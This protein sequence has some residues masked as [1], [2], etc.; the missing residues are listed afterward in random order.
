MIFKWF[1]IFGVWI[2]MDSAM[3]QGDVNI[4][5]GKLSM[6]DVYVSG[7]AGY[8]TFR[9]PAV[10]SAANGDL[11]AFAEGRKSGRSDAGNIDLVVKRSHDGGVS[12]S[13]MNLIWDDAENTCGNP[14]PILDRVTGDIHLLAT[15]NSG[16][17]RE[18]EII[19]QTSVDSRRVY[20]ITSNDHGLT[21]SEP[22]EITANVKEPHWTWYATGPGSGIQ[23]R[24]GTYRGRLM[25]GCD[26]IEADTKKYYSHVIYS[27]DHGENW[28]LGGSTP[29]DQVN[30]C[31][32]AELPRDLLMLNMRNYDRSKKYRQIAISRDGGTTWRDQ[33]HDQVLVEPICQ[34][35]LHVHGSQK[36]LIFSNPAN[37]DD[38]RQM[39]MRFSS[40]W[41]YT[42]P[43]SV[44]LYD[45]PAAYSDIVSVSESTIGC[46]FE[47]GSEHP[48]ER[49]VFA[50]ISM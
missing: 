46:L 4:P 44:L 45:G 41:G 30:E 15:W 40:D 48:Y 13:S 33:H 9:I 36:L 37:A 19:N 42:W 49:I 7:E 20:H 23:I 50:R 34:G 8:H 31:E 3:V 18:P 12:W 14:A 1:L 6:S 21:W 10:I 38:R 16:D 32:V 11:L 17:D 29:V 47:M 5:S 27:D 25:V 28:I 39:R 2:T 26:H 24:T 22:R 35:S 43:T